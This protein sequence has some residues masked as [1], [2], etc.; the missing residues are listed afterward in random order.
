M[1]AYDK[2]HELARI[3]ADTE[4]Y[5][6][7]V[8]AKERLEKDESN[9]AMLHE[10]QRR[11]MELQMAQWAGQEVTEEKIQQVEGIYQIISLNPAVNEFL[12]AEYRFSRL[13]TDIHK[14]IVG[15]VKGYFDSAMD[16]SVN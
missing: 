9:L 14:I 16:K 15:A 1:S 2:A 8:A 7:F 13:M 5:K 10:F 12:T 4:E 6:G 11:Q 3:L